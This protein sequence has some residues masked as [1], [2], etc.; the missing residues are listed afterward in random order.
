MLEVDYPAGVVR[1]P[2]SGA[3]VTL[4][5]FPPMIEQIYQCGGLPEF[6]HQRYLREGG[7]GAA[8]TRVKE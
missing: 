7:S 6:A 2:S 3:A 5:K 1:N 8:G 4:R